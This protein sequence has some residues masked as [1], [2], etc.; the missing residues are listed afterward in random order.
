MHYS[1]IDKCDDYHIIR[2]YKAH[3]RVQSYLFDTNWRYFTWVDCYST[4]FRKRHL[5][6]MVYDDTQSWRVS[7]TL[8]VIV[9]VYVYYHM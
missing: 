9:L 4:V 3:S 1:I 7:N 8:R 5:L 6:L 2:N